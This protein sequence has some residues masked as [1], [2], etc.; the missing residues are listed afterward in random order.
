[1]YQR[2]S[3]HVLSL[4]VIDQLLGGLYNDTV[5]TDIADVYNGSFPN[6]VVRRIH[7][8][9]VPHAA[10]TTDKEIYDGLA[11]AGFKTNLGPH[12]T[13]IVQLLL[14]HAGGYYIDTGT[15]QHIIDGDIKIKS[16]SAIERFTEKGLKF[17]DGTEV[18]ADIIIFATGYG[19][20]RDS[21]RDICG[22]QVADKVNPV[23][24]LTEEGEVNSIWRGCGHDGIWFGIGNLGMSRFYS[25]HL[26][27]QIKAIEAGILK[28]SEVKF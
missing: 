9:T 7:Q 14:Q 24:G 6:A 21:M 11:K 20:P 28:R 8:R 1:M 2:S 5:P 12:G 16:G 15:S 13:G 26:A 17:T 27:L 23:W 19:D 18:E 10:Q 25:S 22:P 4:A 3:T